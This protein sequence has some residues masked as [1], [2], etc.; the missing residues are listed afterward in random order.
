[1][2]QQTI[3]W[4]PLPVRGTVSGPLTVSVMLSMRLTPDG[5]AG[6]LSAF[7]DL[8]AWPSVPITWA[9]SFNGASVP[10]TESSAGKLD[11]GLWSSTFPGSTA[12][13]HYAYDDFG[14]SRL[15]SYPVGNV[16]DFVKQQYQ[17]IAVTSPTVKVP[18]TTMFPSE[19]GS[20]AAMAGGVDFNPLGAV[21]DEGANRTAAIGDLDTQY[22]NSLT[23]SAKGVVDTQT[24]FLRADQFFD[25]RTVEAVPATQAQDLPPVATPSLDFHEL[26]SALGDHPDVL[27]R[28]GLLRDLTVTPPPGLT[29]AVTIQLT[30]TPHHAA[31]PATQD[32][33]PVTNAFVANG[34]LG[35]ASSAGGMHNGL[36]PL[37]TGDFT[38]TV[39]DVD[40]AATKVVAFVRSAKR[41]NNS[42]GM[43]LPVVPQ[44]GPPQPAPEPPGYSNP[45]H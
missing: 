9:V 1:M 35:A 5:G 24:D 44:P 19:G 37:N 3:I 28:L 4:T 33:C 6:T 39:I 18:L 26:V 13:T 15:R 2:A 16:H 45:P 36:L 14:A 30:P 7:P 17:Q 25:R 23:I 11:A 22:K 10:A 34:I 42:F 27:R 41:V 40:G 38:P 20:R 31:G 29:G 21:T 43:P 12:V 8:A 32:T